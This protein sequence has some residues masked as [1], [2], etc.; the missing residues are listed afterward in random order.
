MILTLYR[1]S[2]LL[3][4]PAFRVAFGDCMQ[5][6]FA[7]GLSDVRRSPRSWALTMW[8]AT[9]AW[10][11]ARSVTQQWL[12]TSVPW[13]TTLYSM[14]ILAFLEGISTAMLHSR[15]GTPDVAAPMGFHLTGS[16]VVVLG[17]SALIFA[18]WF[19]VPNVRRETPVSL[20]A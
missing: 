14:A 9:V 19:I 4:P 7:D 12:R 17:V 10:D 15:W 6:D 13:L 18:L 5:A 16:A 20:R 11:L 8:L 3:F 2:L 1:A